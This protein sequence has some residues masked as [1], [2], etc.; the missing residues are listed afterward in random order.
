MNNTRQRESVD[1]E[2]RLHGLSAMQHAIINAYDDGLSIAEIVASTGYTEAQVRRQMRY[3]GVAGHRDSTEISVE[4][5]RESNIAFL[6]ALR[7][8]H[9]EQCAR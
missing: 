9:P 6:R 3:C 2:E 8:V 4:S 5:A 7:R 1:S